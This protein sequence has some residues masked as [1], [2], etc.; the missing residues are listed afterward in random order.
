VTTLG[1]FVLREARPTLMDVV[2][3]LEARPEVKAQIDGGITRHY[4]MLTMHRWLRDEHGYPYGA[5]S[6]RTYCDR[7]RSAT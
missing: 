7:V 1:D 4:P 5:T 6:L 3:W 2:R